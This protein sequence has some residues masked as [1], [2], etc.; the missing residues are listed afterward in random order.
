MRTLT[1]QRLGAGILQP[2]TDEDGLSNLFIG[3]FVLVGALILVWG[4][5][6]LGNSLRV[7]AGRQGLTTVRGLFGLHFTR[8][9]DAAEI[10]AI[11]RSIGMQ[12]SQGTRSRAYYQIKVLTRDGRRITAGAGIPGASSVEDIIQRIKRALDLP[13]AWDKSGKK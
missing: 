5:Y 7:T 6:L 9:V 11:E 4:L 13:G 12:A 10:T 8:H 2:L 1:G 3:L